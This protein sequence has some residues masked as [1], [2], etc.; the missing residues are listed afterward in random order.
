MI[1]EQ[2]C[3]YVLNLDISTTSSLMIT[4][5][6]NLNDFFLLL[7]KESNIIFFSLL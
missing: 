7:K 2:K 5:R 1:P 4:S 3:A 6:E